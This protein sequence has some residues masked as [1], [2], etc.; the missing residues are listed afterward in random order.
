MFYDRVRGILQRTVTL[1]FDKI[2][3]R[4]ISSVLLS[5]NVLLESWY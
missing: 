2:P 3:A 4:D 1:Q 5:W